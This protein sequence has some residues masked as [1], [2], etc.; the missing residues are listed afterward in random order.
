MNTPVEVS[1]QK[2]Y[3]LDAI[4]FNFRFRDLDF[5]E[6]VAALH[7]LAGWNA[8][9]DLSDPGD[10]LTQLML[11]TIYITEQR[12]NPPTQGV[13]VREVSAPALPPSKQTTP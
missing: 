1:V 3:Y 12:A 4:D 10:I 5:R 8:S 9:L 11:I 7:G 6:A 13:V 2:D